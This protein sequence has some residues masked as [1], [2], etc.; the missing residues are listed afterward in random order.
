VVSRRGSDPDV[1]IALR[2]LAPVSSKERDRVH[3]PAALPNPT[4][5]RPCGPTKDHARSGVDS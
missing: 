4:T 3:A 1:S 2:S 5:E